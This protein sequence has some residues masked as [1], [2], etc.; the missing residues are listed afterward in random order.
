M[1][2]I[3]GIEEMAEDFNIFPNPTT[4]T[5]FVK[6]SSPGVVRIVDMNGQERHNQLI[7][8]DVS[9]DVSNYA[10]GL[11]LLTLNGKQQKFIKR[12]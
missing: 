6:A 1:E 9:I 12:R 2:V 8:N 7:T 5:L 4:H 10:D 11:Y 3:T